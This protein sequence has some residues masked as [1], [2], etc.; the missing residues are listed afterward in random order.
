[1]SF[2][3]DVARFVLDADAVAASRTLTVAAKKRLIIAAGKMILPRIKFH[4]RTIMSGGAAVTN[5]EMPGS[6][7][8]V[9]A[10]DDGR[11]HLAGS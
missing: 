2:D 8:P 1:L 4:L 7:R 11:A 9:F 6:Y 10:G 3:P 5:Q